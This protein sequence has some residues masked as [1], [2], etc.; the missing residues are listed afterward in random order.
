MAESAWQGDKLNV[1]ISYSR[2]DL[3]FADQLDAALGVAGFGTSID[4]HG[5][6]VGEDWR[7]RLGALIRDADTVVFVLS[8]S[9]ARS[10]ICAWEVAEAVRL[11]KRILPV[12]C[13][14]PDGATPPPL[15]GL[16]YIF[17]YAE[18]K[19]PGSGFGTGLVR[20]ARA[21]NTD[22]DWL[23]EHTRYL[24]RAIKWDAGGRPVNRLLAG[25]DIA[26][27]KAWAARQPKSA[28]ESTELQ[29]DFIKASEAEEVRFMAPKQTTASAWPDLQ[30][31]RA[32]P[33]R[34]RGP[35]IFIC[36]AHQDSVVATE[37]YER[38]EKLGYD[39]WLDKMNLIA[40]QKWDYEIKKAVKEAD[41]FVILL[42]KN[43][44]SKKGYIQKEF[45]LAIESLDDI[46][47][48]QIYL[49]PIKI[50]NCL[51]PSQFSAFH[52]VDLH[53]TEA[54]K[55]VQKAIQFQTTLRQDK[56]LGPS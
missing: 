5:I 46:P 8:P 26:T 20:L 49:I 18:P 39:P 11:G 47:E 3:A 10:D 4:R 35:K 40:G 43:S 7:T 55:Q 15:A 52:W 19:N 2:E 29:L 42:S 56:A 31:G 12:L 21:L 51:V 27:A 23:R 17:F 38:L 50:D 45:K 53:G 24:Q 9:S 16:D 14:P 30:A 54:F 33:G 41:F 13:R 32:G 36:H 44:V 1:F 37:I 22:L 6:F 28:P 48:G 34:L 25:S